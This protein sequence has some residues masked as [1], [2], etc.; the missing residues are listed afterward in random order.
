MPS[1]LRFRPLC[2]QLALVC[3]LAAAAHAAHA[4][5][6]A[7]P[8][9]LAGVH[10]APEVQLGDASL[11]LNGA[12]IRYKAI[13]KVYAA[14]LY[15]TRKATTPAEVFAAPGPKRLSITMLREIDS[16]ELGKLFIRGVEDNMEPGEM[17]HLVPGL[18]R[19]SQVFSDQKRLNAGDTFTIDWLPGKGTVVTVRG[20]PQGEP[21]AEPAFFEAMLR[22]WLGPTPADSSLE[23]A[24]LGGGARPAAVGSE[25]TA[26]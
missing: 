7:A 20:Q 16:S 22:I 4:A 19:M 24:L 2:S 5:Q 15:L 23:K 14:G 12:G 13:F 9:D 1:S 3:F 11:L 17:K 6:T 21:F 25:A 18:L 10:F 8:V 26:R